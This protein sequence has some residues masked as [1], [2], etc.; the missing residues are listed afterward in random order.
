MAG[1]TAELNPVQ[2]N[3]LALEAVDLA[4]NGNVIIHAVYKGGG[5]DIAGLREGDM[6]YRFNGQRVKNVEQFQAIVTRTL[7][8][9]TVKVDVLRNGEKKQF[10]VLVGEGEMQ[11]AVVPVANPAPSPLPGTVF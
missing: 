9:T 6:L 3:K 10:V 11:G 5:A 1:G 7:K 4:G 8:E 2:I